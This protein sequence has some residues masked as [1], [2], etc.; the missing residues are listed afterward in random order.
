MHATME[1]KLLAVDDRHYQTGKAIVILLQLHEHLID[2][3]I[4]R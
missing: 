2:K 3:E 4:I 1:L